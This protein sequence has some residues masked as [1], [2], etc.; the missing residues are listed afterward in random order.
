MTE[1]DV[2]IQILNSFLTTPHGKLDDL[3]PLHMARSIAT[4]CST[5][6]WRHGTPAAARCAT[7]RC[8]SSPIC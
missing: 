2:R 6:T 7:I 4:R 1:I 5:A 3:A 8:C